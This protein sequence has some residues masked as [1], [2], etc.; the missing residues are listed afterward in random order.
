MKHTLITLTLA[1][2]IISGCTISPYPKGHEDTTEA[3]VGN[4]VS[5]GYAQRDQG[6]DFVTVSVTP[7]IGKAINIKIRS[8]AD[9]K[10]APICNFDAK[11][12]WSEPSVYESI[13]DYATIRYLFNDNGLHI[14]TV[15]PENGAILEQ[16]CTDGVSIAGDYHKIDAYIE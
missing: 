10:K 1:A 7:E 4:Y 15:K 5:S 6:Q 3:V 16:F 14:E 9:V 12:Y 2:L 8:R 13:Y 11:V